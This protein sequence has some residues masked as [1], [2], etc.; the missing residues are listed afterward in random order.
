MSG[1]PDPFETETQAPS[2]DRV[3]Q[4]FLTMFMEHQDDV[5]EIGDIDEQYDRHL[6]LEVL[7]EDDD[8]IRLDLYLIG[9][10]MAR[11]CHVVGLVH[12]Q[13]DAK[14]HYM[15]YVSELG[16]FHFSWLEDQDFPNLTVVEPDDD[17]FIRSPD[18]LKQIQPANMIFCEAFMTCL[19]K[20]TP[21]F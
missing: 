7:I 15:I 3:R 10:E 18:L 4:R 1:M 11:S 12:L 9:E 16:V 20:S 2:H 8:P 21:R 13:P 19:E 6:E 14:E 17:G 5:K